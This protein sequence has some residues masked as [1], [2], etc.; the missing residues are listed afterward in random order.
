MYPSI[1]LEHKVYPPHLGEAFLKVYGKIK[2]ERIEAKKAGNKLKDRTLKLSINGPSGNLQNEHS[3]VYSPK[4]ALQIR[5]NGQL[6]LLMLIEE[7]V[8]ADIQ[9]VNSNTDGAY[10]LLD[11]SKYP[12]L[13]EICRDWE[14]KTKLI[15][16]EDRFE[17]FYQFAINDYLG[18]KEGYAKTKDPNLLKKKGLFIDSVTLGKGMAPMII[19]EAINKYLADGI[20]PKETI[21]NCKDILKFCTYQKVAKK[22]KVLYGDQ[23]VQ[24]INRYY[25]S[26]NGK[27]IVKK[28]PNDSKRKPTALCASSPVTIYNKFDDKDISERKINYTFYLKEIKKILNALDN[29]QL[30]L[31]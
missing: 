18:V 22:F 1:I 7:C 20:D 29:P 6:M 5:L 25:M 2:E 14:K 28:D 16:E 27:Y 12:K 11:K 17:R 26:T 4:T 21:D 23:E 15:L 8:L 31:F 10:V 3:W 13:Q 30:S 24:H 9:L 19:P